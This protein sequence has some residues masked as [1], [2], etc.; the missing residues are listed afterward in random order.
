MPSGSRNNQKK[1]G[2]H[3]IVREPEEK[4][5]LA[6]A[7]SFS[8]VCVDE[9]DLGMVKNKFDPEAKDRH[10][11]RLVWQLEDE[12]DRRHL[13]A[14]D[15]T[16]SLHEKAALRG[17][18]QTWR[19]REFTF[20]ELVGFDLEGVIGVTCLLAVVHKKGNKGGT[21]SNVGSVMKLPKSMRPIEAIDYIRMKDRATVSTPRKSRVEEAPPNHFDGVDDSDIP[22]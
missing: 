12:D 1:E 16:A 13:I 21:F 3:I 22:F 8:A 6:P 20:D 7:G 19:G 17:D 10:M 5:P 4:F 2:I 11:V 14:K 18:L 9:I 15:Y